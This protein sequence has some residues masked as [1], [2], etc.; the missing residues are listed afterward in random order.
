MIY[1]LSFNRADSRI[2]GVFTSEKELEL[3]RDRIVHAQIHPSGSL[4]VEQY[5]E[6]ELVMESD[7]LA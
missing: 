1:I 3:A 5:S 7:M 6:N 4:F 2:L